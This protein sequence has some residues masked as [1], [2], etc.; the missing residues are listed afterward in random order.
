MQDF[1]KLRDADSESKAIFDV[2]FNV[3]S[4]MAV[5]QLERL[6][7]GL[8]AANKFIESTKAHLAEVFSLYWALDRDMEVWLSDV[9]KSQ[10]QSWIARATTGDG[11]TCTT[12]A[13]LS[14]TLK[15]VYEV[16]FKGLEAQLGNPKNEAPAVAR[17]P[18]RTSGI[19]VK[20]HAS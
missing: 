16:L 19:D 2:L 14:K 10:E 4:Q 8:A 6:F 20:L 3:D 17:G 12:P 13:E 11:S 7:R 5:R 15:R 9:K 1:R 18:D